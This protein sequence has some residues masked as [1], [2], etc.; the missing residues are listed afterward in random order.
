MAVVVFD[1]A[2]FKVRYPEFVTAPNI[3]LGEYFTESGLYLNNTDAS[4]VCDVT[5]R[6]MLLNMLVAH[7]AALRFGVN[8]NAPSGLVGR[9]SSA[10]E[11]AC[12]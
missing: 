2:A 1:P 11:G 9:V 5:I 6:A 10:T 4:P 8:G 3:L 12:P 7:I